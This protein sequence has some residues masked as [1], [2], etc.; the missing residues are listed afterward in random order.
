MGY[1]LGSIG[2]LAMAVLVIPGMLVVH[3]F[4]ARAGLVAVLLLG[5]GALWWAIRR[6]TGLGERVVAVVSV[7]VG[8]YMLLALLNG[9]IIFTSI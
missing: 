3:E 2:L 1:L 7:V 6:F 8:W 9:I 4:G 5:G